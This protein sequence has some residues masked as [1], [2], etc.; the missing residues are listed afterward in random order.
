[1]TVEA[2]ADLLYMSLP[3]HSQNPTTFFALLLAHT[4]TH[5]YTQSDRTIRLRHGFAD[6]TFAV[7]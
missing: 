6:V 2:G 1:M 5:T 4:H 3:K 7:A